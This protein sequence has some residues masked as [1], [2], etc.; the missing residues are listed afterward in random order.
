MKYFTFSPKIS[1]ARYLFSCVF[2]ATM[3]LIG[4]A[5]FTAPT[6]AAASVMNGTSTPIHF[7][8]AENDHLNDTAGNFAT[9]S[10]PEGIFGSGV[11]GALLFGTPYKDANFF[12]FAFLAFLGYLTAKIF[13]RRK[14]S[15]PDN[16]FE[17]RSQM[18]TDF[19][20]RNSD[21]NTDRSSGE[22]INMPPLRPSGL[23]RRENPTQQPDFPSR[24][25]PG[26]HSDPYSQH[27]G[28]N[29]DGNAPDGR[30][31]Q[32]PRDNAWSRR[33]GGGP[34]NVQENAAA[35]WAAFSSKN[36]HEKAPAQ[37]DSVMPGAR[38]PQNFDVEDFLDGARAL[39][40]KLQVAWAERKLD[41]LIPFMTPEMML[42]LQKQAAKNPDPSPVEVLLVTATL[43][44]VTQDGQNELASALFHATM[45][46]G[47]EQNPEIIDEIWHFT[48][49]ATEKSTWRLSGISPAN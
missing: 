29:F 37:S 9:T 1:R 4:N 18:P 45:R 47:A 25:A 2:F 27:S 43:K 36:D 11:L 30:A 22:D 17:A 15:K 32:N 19:S 31:P 21:H 28:P 40:G 38:V 33:L 12:D 23:K 42:L 10:E 34:Q 5:L 13:L 46:F 8:A 20:G 49:S 39:Y 48:R 24:T 26:Q 16:K 14:S 6:P 44:D 41:S 35:M 3:L 7:L